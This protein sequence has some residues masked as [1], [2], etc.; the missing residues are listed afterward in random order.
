M[1]KHR[2]RYTQAAIDD[3]DAI[4]D[5]IAVED[6]DAAIKLLERFDKRITQL[7]DAPYTGAAVSSDE[8]TMV[9]S[10]YRYATVLPYLIFYRVVPSEVRIGRILHS[11]Q[12]WLHLL[13]GVGRPEEK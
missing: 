9:A 3:L 6:R 4:F 13:F 7:A 11:R 10:G 5:Y 8:L 12:D 1:V 2:I